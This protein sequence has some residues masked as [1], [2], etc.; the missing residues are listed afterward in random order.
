MSKVTP[1]IRQYWDI[2]NEH[3]EKI[4][5]FRV[6]DFYEM[7]YEDAKIAAR[8]LEIVLTSRE[9][10]KD[11]HVPLAGFPFHAASSY[12]S[13]LIEKGYKVA[14]CDQVED[15]KSVKG[16]VKRGVTSIITPG[17]VLDD[18]L[19]TDTS[20][21]YLCS[22]Y[23][24]QEGIGLA[25]IDVSTGDFFITQFSGPHR[26][27][28]FKDELMK[29]K[30]TE[31][32]Y[33][34]AGEEDKTL[35]KIFTILPE[36]LHSA[37]LDHCF[38]HSKAFETL[39]EQFNTVSLEG[40]GCSEFP[41]G[42]NAG[43]AVISYINDLHKSSLK[44]INNLSVYHPEDYMLIDGITRRNLELTQTIRT[45]KKK[46]A[47]LGVLDKT[48]TSLGG[49][50]IRKWLEQ[51]LLDR[52][53]IE[54]RLEGVEE[55]IEKPFLRED[56]EDL[57]EETYDL[58][59][60]ISRI[61]IGTANARDLIHLKNTLK[62]FPGVRNLL[63]QLD[64]SLFYELNRQFNSLEDLKKLIDN[65]LVEEPPVYLKE[66]GLIKEGYDREL[67]EIREI[68]RKGKSWI[69]E[70]E[71]K[72]RERTGIKSLK[73]TFNK[74][75][76]YFIEV[77]RA[78]LSLVPEDY[79]RKQTLVNSERFVTPD[80][81]EYEEKILGAQEKI[82][83]KEYALFDQVRKKAASH[84]MEI[85]ESARII[86]I[87]DCIL[88]FAQVA[89]ENNYCRP[90]FTPE[91]SI[92][93]VD[94]RHPV[95]E[96][97]LI[98]EIFVPNDTC[99]DSKESRLLIITGPNMAGKST[100]MRQ[101]ALIA[102][103][104]QIG[105]FVPAKEAALSLTD[106][107]FA[108]VGAADDLV[109]GQS[110]FMIEMNE[111]AN[112]LNNATSR[113]L[114]ILDEIG[115][116]TSTFD[117]MSIARAVME[118]LHDERMIGAKTLF[119]TH[120]HELTELADNLPGIKN[121]SMAV[122]E[123]GEDIVFLRKII[124]ERADRSYGIQVARLA[125]LPSLVVE[126]A[127]EALKELEK[128]KSEVYPANSVKEKEFKGYNP[129]EDLEDNLEDNLD[130]DVGEV[131]EKDVE[132]TLKILLEDLKKMD[133]LNMTPLEALDKIFSMQDKIMNTSVE[134]G[135]DPRD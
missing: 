93:I 121:Y 104:A 80:L 96:K 118:Y 74:V 20:N 50:L 111:V 23:I 82:Q 59:R 24:V 54:E 66:G 46:G 60:I 17:T 79:I 112:I 56:L 67:D 4:L 115:R 98:D 128:E 110:T 70:L 48:T 29:Y 30:P 113:S 64:S 95:V 55:F 102:L 114:I 65:A 5:F 119:A 31:C 36:M 61:N 124:P 28:R 6:G 92:K 83:E 109:G 116:G 77:T 38:H 19:L 135:R 123:K 32:V 134:K 49:R 34:S 76:G 1:M 106:R 7:F 42:V 57:L 45:G 72:E 9:T 131:L 94:G 18:N 47:L 101:V 78:N 133:P 103:M 58:E 8:E 73:V 26:Y 69:M 25:V 68:S 127:S 125:G 81:K 75:F 43:G 21:N 40:F 85:Q 71:K 122:K 22:I 100:Y 108:R 41:L 105:S 51:P 107:I 44:H 99:L 120:Y 130:E 97:F 37:Y 10:G 13:R 52:D 84:T 15:A 129:G 27:E 12:I 53:R 14:I 11:N 62:T 87:L 89:L 16:L 86:A 91:E 90:I 2:K 117:G 39:T 88:N 33:N 3:E 35:Q 63:V 132:E 126:R